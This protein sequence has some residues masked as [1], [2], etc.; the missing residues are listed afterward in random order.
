MFASTFLRG[1][2]NKNVAGG[3]KKLAGLVGYMMAVCDMV[4]VG[5]IVKGG[6]TVAFIAAIGA[7]LG[8]M[9]GMF[10]HDAIMRKR[11]EERKRTKKLRK[12]THRDMELER[13]IDERLQ[14][15]GIYE[16]KNDGY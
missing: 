10:A 12:Q 4:T 5:L 1:F 16:R 8:W 9:A 15:L 2:Q 3:Y 14:E 11:E 6:M 7:G 13:K